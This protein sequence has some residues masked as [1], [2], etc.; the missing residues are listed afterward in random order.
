MDAVSK[1]RRR[2]PFPGRMDLWAEHS[3][4]FHGLHEQM[5]G[6]L[7]LVLSEELDALGYFVG[8]E[9]S[10]QVADGQIPDIHLVDTKPREPQW[11]TTYATAARELLLDPGT[12]VTKESRLTALYIYEQSSSDLVC[13]FEIVSP[14]NKKNDHDISRYVDDRDEEFLKKGVNVVEWDIT[15]SYKRLTPNHLTEA[16]P[17]HAAILIAGYELRVV[18]MSLN[19]PFKSVGLPLSRHIVPVDLQHLYEWAYQG[20]NL[21]GLMQHYKH[22]TLDNLPFPSLLTDAERETALAAVV[23]WDAALQEAQ[24]SPPPAT[25]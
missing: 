21:A 15:R 6:E 14:G 1:L 3:G 24:N 11:G 23:A 19:Q 2:G 22:Y 25:P 13:V 8:R 16:S 10:L 9:K 7:T 18:Q 4:F 20:M 5:I 17:Y 12:V